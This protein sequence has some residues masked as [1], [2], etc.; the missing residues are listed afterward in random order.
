M[1]TPFA[2]G[3]AAQNY[4]SVPPDW[5]PASQVR[6]LILEDPALLWLEYHGAQFGFRPDSSPYDYLDF[7]AEKSR[8]FEAKWLQEMAPGAPVVCRDAHDV[9]SRSKFEETCELMRQG[10]PCIAQPALW[11]APER[12]Y[13]AP[14][15]LVLSS[16]LR[17][18]F[19]GLPD[20]STPVPDQYVV[21]D[22][23]FT[24][25]IDESS[26]AKDRQSYAAQVRLYSYMLGCLQ[27]VMPAQAFLVTRDR[28]A[29]PF[30]VEITSILGGQLDPDLAALRDQFVEIKV[31]GAAY[32]PW[33]DA[34]VASNIGNADERWHTAK[35]VI[36]REKTPGRDPALVYQI[37]AKA[38]QALVAQGYLSLDAVLQTDPA[39]LPLEDIRGIGASKAR[40]IRA[41]LQA[42]RTGQPLLPPPEALPPRKP[43]EFFVD[44]EYFTNV[45]VDFERQ[46]PTLEG[47]E[48][49]F[50]VGLGWEEAGRWHFEPLI[51][52]AE[53][54]QAE[55]RLLD[56]FVEVLQA[57]TQ[58]ALADPAQAVLYHWTAAE[59]WQTQRA[60]DRHVLPADHP[61]RSL[62]WCDL[63]KILLDGPAALPG[64]LAYGLKEVAAAVGVCAPAYVTQ[65]PGDLDQGLNAMVMGWKAYQQ[66][67]PLETREFQLLREYL[68][69]DC[70]ALR[71]ILG[72]LRESAGA[73]SQ[74]REA[75]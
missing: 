23:K 54:L 9:T 70:A 14:D 41:V 5:L 50:M 30:P 25:K 66:P 57:R 51:A 46:W 60:A 24:T 21:I 45:D 64:A 35:Q 72:W 56:R 65:W 29:D 52:E 39:T 53:D 34:I 61:L 47:H 71:N 43:C 20:V 75:R 6:P 2:C 15:L 1:I 58:G 7:I 59:V 67:S 42:N 17:R 27:G 55:R 37:G 63:Q 18:R 40:Q 68:G 3:Q 16:W 33:R 19:P 49:I 11:W 62:P 73:G 44:F 10:V 12:I 22:L 4:R 28:L 36:A 69:S 38:K 48:M 74:F 13:G 26:K 31:N 32:L 8:Q